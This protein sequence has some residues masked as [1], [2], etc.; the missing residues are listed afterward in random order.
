[1]E[2]KPKMYQNKVNKEFHNN[3][4][5]YTSIDKEKNIISNNNIRKKI[6]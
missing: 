4:S 5:V 2:N 3:L 1:M 6:E